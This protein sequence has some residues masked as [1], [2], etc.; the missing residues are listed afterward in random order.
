MKILVTGGA[1][2]IGS[3]IVDSYLEAGHEVLVLDNLS[4]GAIRNINPK[5]KF[6]Q[7]DICSSETEAIFKAEKPDIVNHLAAHVSVPNSIMDPMYDTQVNAL[8]LVNILQACIKYNTHKIIFSSSGGAIYGDTE[9]YPTKETCTPL[10]LSIYAINKMAGEQYIK[11]YNHHHGLNYTILRYANVYGPRQV[12]QG[13]GGVVATFISQMLKGITPAIYSY[14]ESPMG[15]IRDYV[16]VADV[17]YANVQALDLGDGE[18]INIGTCTETNT[19]EL[20]NELALQIGFKYSA[21]SGSARAGDLRRNLL[22]IDKAKEVLNW[23]PK[24]SLKDGIAQTID[25]FKNT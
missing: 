18:T 12:S 23:E 15:M 11:F 3:H 20:Y 14:P 16:Y 13:E 25:Y 17:V 8:G 4:S 1:G 7:A 5:A 19:T 24:Y 6:Y 2:F 10:P 9:E 21:A 22:N